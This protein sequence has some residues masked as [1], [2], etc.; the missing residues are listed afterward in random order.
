MDLRDL[1]SSLFTG[2][3]DPERTLAE[4]GPTLRWVCLDALAA[5]TRAQ[6]DALR[7]FDPFSTQNLL[8][9]R[10]ALAAGSA[11]VGPFPDAIAREYA[12]AAFTSNS[13]PW[14][15]VPPTPD[16]LRGMIP[17]VP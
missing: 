17:D 5:P 16:E 4:L 6:L 2:N 11:R 9:T 7:V 8:Q 13:M 12:E 15:L 1:F 14:R 3:P 10:R